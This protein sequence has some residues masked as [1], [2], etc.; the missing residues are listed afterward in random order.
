[1]LLKQELEVLR[2]KSELTPATEDLAV[3]KMLARDATRPLQNW[4]PFRCY[5]RIHILSQPLQTAALLVFDIAL[6]LE[7]AGYRRHLATEMSGFLLENIL[8]DLDAI[9]AAFSNIDEIK[10]AVYMPHS[11]VSY[12]EV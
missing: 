1:M 5:P 10:R 11:A 2:G 12:F 3:K 9:N 8:G 7:N 4:R 6:A